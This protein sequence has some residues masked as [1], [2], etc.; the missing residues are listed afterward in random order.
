MEHGPRVSMGLPVYNGENFLERQLESLLSQTFTDFE[1]V[2]SD[3]A[4]EDRTEEICRR[5][6]ERDPRIRYHRSDVNHGLAW[7]WNR[8]FELSRAPYFKWVAHD[9]EHAE[10]FVERCVEVLDADPT[11]VCCHSATVDVDPEGRE[12]RQW[13]ARTLPASERPSVRL[14]DMLKPYPAF[15]VYGL[16]RRSVLAET[17][18]HRPI[19]EI[20]H[21]LLAEVALRGR[22][23]ELPEP[24]FRRREHPA[25]S[26]RA[27]TT[28]RARRELYRDPTAGR[29]RVADW[30]GV[31][32][33]TEMVRA[34]REAPVRGRE[35]VLCWL[36]LRHW[37]ARD[38]RRLGAHLVREAL[39]R[40][41]REDLLVDTGLAAHLRARLP[42][43]G[44]SGGD[45]ASA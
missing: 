11:V 39:A 14:A 18:L 19:P 16:M 27:F 35:R 23:V 44:R 41:G 1:L 13:P 22:I 21:A 12:I 6:A 5:F 17:G 10:T 2:I 20:D 37:L 15:Q 8:V 36:A 30:P 38:V 3:N 25:R 9:D 31:Q 24:L 45:S 33:S 26:V 4:S 34:V 42:R 7:N 29:A 32:L 43:R 40:A 28:A